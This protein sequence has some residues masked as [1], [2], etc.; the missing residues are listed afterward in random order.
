MET[1]PV[2]GL[3]HLAGMVVSAVGR[4]VGVGW[5]AAGAR[6]NA[7]GENLD[8]WVTGRLG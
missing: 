8:C 7:V 6:G 4:L 2:S 3:G 1:V 5:R